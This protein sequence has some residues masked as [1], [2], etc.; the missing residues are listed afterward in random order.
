MTCNLLFEIRISN[1]L[2][3]RITF[4]IRYFSPRIPVPDV[5]TILEHK[6]VA[7][8]AINIRF[9]IPVYNNGMPI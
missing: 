9:N 4:C 5:H 2:L 8:F 1:S 6:N 3:I 7:A